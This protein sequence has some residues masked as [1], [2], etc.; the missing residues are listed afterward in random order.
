M[1]IG[2][3]ARTFT[4]DEPGGAVKF[5]KKAHDQLVSESDHEIISF[6]PSSLDLEST[7]VSTYYPDIGQFYGI[8]WEKTLLPRLTKNHGVDVLFC[9]NANGFI[10]NSS[11]KNIVCI[12]DMNSYHGYSSKLYSQYERTILPRVSEKADCI[13]TV[14]EFSKGEIVNFLN[15]SPEKV[16]VVHNG[17]DEYFKRETTGEP[18]DLPDKYIL[19]VGAL[20]PRKNIE[21]VIK[22]FMEFQEDFP[23][24]KL[25]LIGP[26][27]K[28]VFEGYSISEDEKLVVPGY[29]SKGQL[30]T[31][32]EN[33]DTFLFPSYYE[34]FGIPPLEAMACKTPVVAS[35]TSA[36]P[37]ILGEAALYS[38]PDDHVKI[39]NQISKSVNDQS[40]RE[41]LIEKGV[42]KAAE[43]SWDECAR[44]IVN[45]CE[46]VG[47][48]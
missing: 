14:S 29:V 42:K 39:S 1:K 16:K 3:A 33:A 10:T 5:G 28:K 12:H 43:Y 46:I 18:I 4:V 20:N 13:I 41:S 9:P 44:S 6:G 47:N 26:R 11:T 32:Y 45:I 19:Y 2:I 22:S 25:V 8:L 15:V 27:N 35:N 36:L 21:G 30:K 31:A 40:V 24:Y 48:Q 38:S 17:V 34:G 37:E 7:V 23:E